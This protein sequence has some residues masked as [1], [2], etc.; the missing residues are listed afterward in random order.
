MINE[1]FEVQQYLEGKNINKKCLH[2]VCYLLA[3]WFKEHGLSHLE[4]RNEIFKWGEEHHVFF[5]FSVN[6]VIYQALEDGHKLR[7]E[8]DV[9]ISEAD[10]TE[11]ISRFDSRNCKLLALAILCYAKVNA[12]ANGEVNI[13][14]VAFSNWLGLQQSHISGRYIPELIDFDFIE[15][16]GDEKSYFMWD[17]KQPLS[18]NRRYKIKVPL[19]N[20]GTYVLAGNDIM[21]LAKDVF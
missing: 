11:I 2:R 5:P 16:C 3:V 9:F 17:K 18:K 12:D 10:I 1:V 4:I 14:T 13:S 6:T 8:T 7:G 21:A 15:R 20:K 19:V